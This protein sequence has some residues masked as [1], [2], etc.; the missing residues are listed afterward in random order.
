M[1]EATG[2]CNGA[3]L[4]SVMRV[5]SVYMR[6]MDVHVYGVDLVS[7]LFRSAFAHDIQVPPMA[8]C[9]EGPSVTT[10]DHIWCFCRVNSVRYTVQVI[11]LLLVSFLL[12]VGDVLFSKTVHIHIRPLRRNGIRGI[13]QLP[14]PEISSDLSPNEHVWGMMKRELTLSPEPTIAIAELRHRVQDAWDNLS[15]DDTRHLC[16][17]LR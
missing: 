2:E 13:Q 7:V 1:K 12:Q 10:R 11:N 8:S 15:Q 4:S 9:C 14:F 6:M 16:D 17:R 5:G 3:L